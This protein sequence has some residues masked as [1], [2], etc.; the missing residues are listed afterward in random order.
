MTT[1]I[2]KPARTAARVW[3]WG[4]R[5]PSQK[6]PS[7]SVNFIPLTSGIRTLERVTKNDT[8]A[9]VD[10]MERPNQTQH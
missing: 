6:V 3:S 9:K 10:A 1:A 5:I 2:A 4:F 7:T 8:F